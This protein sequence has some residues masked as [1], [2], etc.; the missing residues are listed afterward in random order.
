MEREWYE[1]GQLK[2]QNRH[3]FGI[4]ME[5]TKWNAQGAVEDHFLRDSADEL[6]TVAKQ[7]REQYG[8]L[9]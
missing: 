8:D 6:A 2:T 5:T 4:L 3:E 1:S 9:V 7:R